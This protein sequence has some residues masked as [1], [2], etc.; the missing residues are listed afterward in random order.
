MSYPL[1]NTGSIGGVKTQTKKFSVSQLPNTSG[2]NVNAALQSA[3]MYPP[4]QPPEPPQAPPLPT[5]P[6]IPDG[7]NIK[8]AS[9]KTILINTFQRELYTVLIPDLSKKLNIACLEWVK[10]LPIPPPVS[11]VKIIYPEINAE[12]LTARMFKLNTSIKEVS[13]I[14]DTL[15]ISSTFYKLITYMYDKCIPGNSIDKGELNNF[16]QMYNN[17]INPYTN[18][19]QSIINDNYIIRATQGGHD[20]EILKEMTTYYGNN[21]SLF[22]NTTARNILM[23]NYTY[24]YYILINTTLMSSI[25]NLYNL[26]HNDNKINIAI[27]TPPNMPTGTIIIPQPLFPIGTIEHVAW[28]NTY[29][30]LESVRT[31]SSTE[32]AKLFPQLGGKRHI[33][34][35]KI[36]RKIRAHKKKYSRRQKV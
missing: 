7:Y 23:A 36:T 17:A 21:N 26:L 24:L 31:Y 15:L 10:L 20:V 30:L 9:L 29:S 2:W 8:L 34:R 28:V 33:L 22:L 6:S 35:Y 12:A 14:T 25:I 32:L 16:V 18:C 13:S 11:Q 3:S 4:P 5:P 19:F 1:I 27:A